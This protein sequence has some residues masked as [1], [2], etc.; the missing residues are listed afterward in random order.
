MPPT[1]DDAPQSDLCGACI[2]GRYRVVE[3]LGKG[4]MSEVYLAFELTPAGPQP[5]ALKRLLP[6]L[7]GEADVVRMFEQEAQVAG[8]FGHGNIARVL[9]VIGAG[10]DSI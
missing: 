2:D 4:G 6:H 1:P 3:K 7:R 10:A 8:R 5:V 9:D